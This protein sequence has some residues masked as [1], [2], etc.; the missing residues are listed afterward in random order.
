MELPL[1]LIQRL[2]SNN[3]MIP[4]FQIFLPNFFEVLE[5]PSSSTGDIK[6]LTP[7]CYSKV[8]Q[9]EI[10]FMNILVKSTIISMNIISSGVFSALSQF[11]DIIS[12]LK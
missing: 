6:L 12:R 7:P 8:G 4:K 2:W 10:D 11:L 9:I 5:M 3:I 1:V